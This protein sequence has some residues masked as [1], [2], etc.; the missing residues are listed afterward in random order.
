MTDRLSLPKYVQIA[1]M[2]IREIA[3]GHLAD[4]A[5][6]AP[7]RE[8]AATL[9]TSVTTLRKALDDLAQK[10]LL[11][12][13]Q[14]SG[15]YIST[16]KTVPSVYAFLR[17]E[18]LSGGGLPTAQVLSV[19]HLP[20]PHGVAFGP[21]QNG[22]RIRRLRSLD[23]D[24][25]ALEE[26]WLDASYADVLRPED[27][28]ESLYLY[29]KKH[30]GFIISRIEDQIGAE[31]VPDWTQG[32]FDPLEGAITPY[33]ERISWSQDNEPAEYSRTWFD[34]NKARYISRL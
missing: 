6:L 3:A 1:E 31:P 2:L 32:A 27:L 33:I 10:G 4:G 9:G 8:M 28:S 16:K 12:R 29:Y 17:L 23:G 18:K 19:D 22:H 11:V 21:A 5:R 13:R 24:V 34:N 25:V 7:E 14:G 30:L 20:K 26:I 15:N